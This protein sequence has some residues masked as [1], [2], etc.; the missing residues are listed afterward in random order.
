MSDEQGT[1]NYEY[2]I[3]HTATIR[4]VKRTLL[5]AAKSEDL[6]LLLTVIRVVI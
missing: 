1:D 2:E 5:V 6:L 3:R 4:N